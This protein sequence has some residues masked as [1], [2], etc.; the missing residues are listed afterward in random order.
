[1]FPINDLQNHNHNLKLTDIE[2][3]F[4]EGPLTKMTKGHR[5]SDLEVSGSIL[6]GE[7][8]FSYFIRSFYFMKQNYSASRDPSLF[9]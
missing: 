7:T 6:G 3:S 8:Q 4:R 1:M 5:S 9:P 2:K